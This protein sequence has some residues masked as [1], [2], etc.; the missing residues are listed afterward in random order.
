[1]IRQFSGFFLTRS[2]FLDDDFDEFIAGVAI[3]LFILFL[4]CTLPPVITL[5]PHMLNHQLAP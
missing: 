2:T 3:C 5:G 1:M 4:L